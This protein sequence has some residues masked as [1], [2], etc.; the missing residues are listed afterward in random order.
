MTQKDL[1]MTDGSLIIPVTVK[2]I[3][4]SRLLKTGHN[5]GYPPLLTIGWIVFI[6]KYFDFGTCVTEAYQGILREKNHSGVQPNSKIVPDWVGIRDTRRSRRALKKHLCRGFGGLVAIFVDPIHDCIESYSS[7]IIRNLFW[8]VCDSK[9]RLINAFVKRKY[10]DL[11]CNQN[12]NI[13]IHQLAIGETVHS[14]IRL[15]LIMYF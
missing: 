4:V 8:H 5:C 7:N 3:F 11:M 13:Y 6:K 14:C 10:L 15:A 2:R 12:S 1:S 9:M